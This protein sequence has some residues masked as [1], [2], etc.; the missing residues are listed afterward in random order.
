MAMGIPVITNAGVGDVK[1]V[2][3]RYNGGFVVHDFTDQSFKTII[4]KMLSGNSFDESA[5]RMGAKEFY[6]LDTAVERYH[7]VYNKIF[8]LDGK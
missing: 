4:D 1:E 5:I 3:N 8:A 6:S 2:V 7:R